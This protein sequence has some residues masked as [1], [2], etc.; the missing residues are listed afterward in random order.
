LFA[1]A[2]KVDCD[3]PNC[4]GIATMRN[5][6]NNNIFGGNREGVIYKE[7]IL[8]LRKTKKGKRHLTWQGTRETGHAARY[9]TEQKETKEEAPNQYF[10]LD[11]ARQAKLDVG[12]AGH[13]ARGAS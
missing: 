13:D 12:G 9:S 10:D 1:R 4:L 11:R 7:R 6:D 8:G 5:L 2:L 3:G